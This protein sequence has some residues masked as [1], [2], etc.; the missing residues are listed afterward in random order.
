MAQAETGGEVARCDL[1]PEVDPLPL[2]N[3]RPRVEGCELI[4]KQGGNAPKQ[5][6][7]RSFILVRAFEAHR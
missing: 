4:V 5:K 1:C 7:L 3:L 2:S 6:V